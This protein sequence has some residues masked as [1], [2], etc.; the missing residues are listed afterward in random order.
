MAMTEKLPTEYKQDEI[1]KVISCPRCG[2]WGVVL[3]HILRSGVIDY[4]VRWSGTD[5]R[6][7]DVCLG[8]DRL[9]HPDFGCGYDTRERRE[10]DRQAFAWMD[11]A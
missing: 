3:I 6:W 11:D 7:K 2:R 9:N 10:A 1:F 4:C 8:L 5:H